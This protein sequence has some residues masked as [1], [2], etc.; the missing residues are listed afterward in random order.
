[1]QVAIVFT[2]FGSST[3][4]GNFG[5]GDRARCSAA[6]ARHLVHDVKCAR[7][8]Q[9]DEQAQPPAPAP[10]APPRRQRRAS[11]LITKES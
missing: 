11:T 1:M 6:Q 10:I 3:A 7:Y 4:L 9:R 8:A 2:T 5:P